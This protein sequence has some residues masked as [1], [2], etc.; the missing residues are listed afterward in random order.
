MTMAWQVINDDELTQA[1]QLRAVPEPA[2][3]PDDVRVAVHA[4]ALG[5]PDVLL[6][7]GQYHDRPELPFSIGGEAAGQVIEAGADALNH[8]GQRVIVVPDRIAHGLMQETLTVPAER[9]LPIPDGMPMAEAAAFVAAYQTAYVGLVR[10]CHLSAGETLLV[11]GASGGIG[12]AA[13]E[14]GR[15]L[16]ARVIAVTKGAGKAAFCADLGADEVI[17]LAEDDRL[18]ATVKELTAGHGADVI[19]DP[20]GGSAT[21]AAR[22]CIALEGRLLIVGFAS[23]HVPAI[24]VNHALLKNYSIVG[25]RTWP[26]RGDPLYRAQ[27]HSALSEMYSRGSCVPASSRFRSATYPEASSAW[28]IVRCRADLLPLSRRTRELA[29]DGR[30]GCRLHAVHRRPRRHIGAR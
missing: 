12:S 22:R 10:R 30:E 16:G 20:V 14:I 5:F 25:F 23:G 27:V 7:K 19:F 15:A 24:P 2:L 13:V 4:C 26:F 17:D 28:S 6:A 11:L 1:V 9:L 21:D 18:A 3:G 29:L 8:V